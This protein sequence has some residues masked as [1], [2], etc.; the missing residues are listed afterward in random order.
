M[1]GGDSVVAEHLDA[2]RQSAQ[3][4]FRALSEPSLGARSGQDDTQVTRMGDDPQ[5]GDA[6]WPA[7]MH[8]KGR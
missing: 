7:T 1:A 6:A 3:R 5:Q 8:S 2:A 4:A